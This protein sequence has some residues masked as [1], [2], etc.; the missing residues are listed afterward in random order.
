[1]KMIHIEGVGD[2]KLVKVSRAKTIRLS[3]AANNSV[4]ISLPTW[5]PYVAA[6]AFARSHVAWLKRT[7][8]KQPAKKTYEDG[9][10]IGKLHHISFVKTPHFKQLSTRVTATRIIVAY[11]T[12]ETIHDQTVQTRAEKAI[13]RALRK[14][15][16]QLLPPRVQ[17]FAEIYG[18]FYG[19]IAAKQL[20]RRWGSCDS[21]KNIVFNFFVMELPWDLIDYVILHELTHTEHMHHGLAFWARLTEICPD[22]KDRRHRINRYRPM[23]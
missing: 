9:Q 23:L 6:E 5:I 20:K 10:K 8:A 11:H 15:T 13:F 3:V 4:R 16:T 12:H 2:I 22:A 14:E 1:M 18:F 17:H 21:R 19:N 7:L